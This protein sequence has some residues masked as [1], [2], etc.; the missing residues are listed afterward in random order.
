MEIENKEKCHFYLYKVF[1]QCALGSG[2]G[3]VGFQDYMKR[4]RILLGGG[5]HFSSPQSRSSKFIKM[6]E[7][8]K[9]E[10]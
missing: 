6:N 4:N 8:L 3:L 2:G 9:F 5:T 10:S 7:I 1:I